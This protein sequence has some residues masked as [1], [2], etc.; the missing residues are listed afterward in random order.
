MTTA[1]LTRW[2]SALQSGDPYRIAG[3]A[4]ELAEAKSQPDT[5]FRF[6]VYDQLWRPVGEI[7]GELMEASGTDPRNNVGS[8]K[9]K[10]KGDSHLIGVFQQCRTT[11]VGVTVETAGPAVGVLRRQL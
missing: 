11:L 6:T 8:A 2:Q 7:G 9:L 10:I 3:T 5:D 4:R 1:E